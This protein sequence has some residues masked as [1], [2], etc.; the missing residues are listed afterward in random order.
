MP[1]FFFFFP[2]GCTSCRI[3]VLSFPIRDRTQTLAL[4]VQNPNHWAAREFLNSL[5]LFST[6]AFL[7]MFSSLLSKAAC[8]CE[9][10][11]YLEASSTGNLGVPYFLAICQLYTQ[12]TSDE[13]VS[14]R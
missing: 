14:M 8:G 13:T 10:Q 6:C 7:K 9:N 12:N 2:F 5:L 3:L 11:R 4:K 1:F